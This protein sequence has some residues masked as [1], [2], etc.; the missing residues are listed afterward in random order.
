MLLRAFR[1]STIN[2]AWTVPSP[3]SIMQP[4][5]GQIRLNDAAVLTVPTANRCVQVISDSIG[6]LPLHAYRN[7]QRID[8]PPLLDQPEAGFT[9]VETVSAWC[10]SLLLH[11]NAYAIIAARDYLG[12]PTDLVTVSPSAVTVK[13]NRDG[14]IE[15][16]VAGTIY[17]PG[18]I[19]H[20]RGTTLAG[21]LTGMGVLELHR[22][23]I[24]QSIAAEDYAGEL[25]TTGAHIDGYLKTDMELNQDEANDIKRR[26]A[27]SHS[28]RQ[29][30]PAVL[31]GGM[32][33]HP[34]QWSNSDLEFLE[35]RKWNAL[36]TAQVFGCPPHMVG[37]PSG[38]SKTY[39]NVQQ[40]SM[41]FVR[42]TL[43]PW[44]ARIESALAGLLPRGQSAG[45]NLDAMLRD[46]TLDRYKAHQIGLAAGFLTVNEVREL[47]DLDPD[48][49]PQPQPTPPLPEGESDE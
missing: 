36:Q 16:R 3:G 46:A 43:R 9:R 5:T 28:G 40:D 12:F 41:S 4:L 10:A 27:E 39:Q 2:R 13:Q 45:F 29:R 19:L 24:G 30:Q 8:T 33:Y 22:R 37:I 35:S 42:Y 21:Q 1:G 38:D 17:D 20:I 15:Y 49:T 11:G 31:Q 23:T 7:N 14:Q 44:L 6:S 32:T 34:V 25:W 48:N 47:E 26:F 18:D